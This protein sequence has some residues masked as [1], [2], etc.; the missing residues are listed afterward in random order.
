MLVITQAFTLAHPI[1]SRSY[2]Y[3]P[4]SLTCTIIRR[5][6]GQ[7]AREWITSLPDA[8]RHYAYLQSKIG[9]IPW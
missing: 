1:K 3:R 7:A 9:Y 8:R 6:V 2:T 4:D 5:E